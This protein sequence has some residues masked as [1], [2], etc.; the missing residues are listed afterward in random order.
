MTNPIPGLQYH[1]PDEDI[2][3]V[4]A[5]L[6]GSESNT[7][8]TTHTFSSKG[9]GSQTHWSRKVIMVICNR[10]QSGQWS[11]DDGCTLGGNTGIV[12]AKDT[13]N[14]TL[15]GG[16]G[17]RFSMAAWEFEAANLG[18]TA[19]LFI[20]HGSTVRDIYVFGWEIT[21]LVF[22]DGDHARDSSGS[23]PHYSRVT[24][25][26]PT[27]DCAWFG[28]GCYY[29]TGKEAI[30]GVANEVTYTWD[31]N[32]D[33]SLDLRARKGYDSSTIGGGTQQITQNTDSGNRSEVLGLSY[34]LIDRR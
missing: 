18:T 14:G 32:V 24:I 29:D 27:G 12:R 5:G 21:G 20:D 34:A 23:S 10:F 16:T 15:L 2:P 8:A 30:D 11:E 6:G 22:F 25:S 3:A 28:A 4:V 9:I 7:D 13:N 17:D 19:D 26:L 33:G 1:A 31:S